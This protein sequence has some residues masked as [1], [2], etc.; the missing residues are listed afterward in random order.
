MRE[1]TSRHPVLPL[2]RPPVADLALGAGLDDHV[3]RLG[4]RPGGIWLPECA[5]SPAWSPTRRRV[6]FSDLGW[7]YV[8]RQ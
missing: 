4:R 6:D 1:L 8:A 5:Y 7:P 2:L 3:L